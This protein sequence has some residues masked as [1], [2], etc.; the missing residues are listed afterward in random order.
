MNEGNEE[1]NTDQH[2]EV[3]EHTAGSGE[4][5]DAELLA[6]LQSLEG[7]NDFVLQQI[8]YILQALN[9]QSIALQA[10]Q[11]ILREEL[12][13]FQTGGP[14]RAMA[15]IFYRLFRDLLKVMNQL[16]ELAA[17]GSSGEHTDEEK[18]WLRSLEMLQGQME[19]ILI[20]WGCETMDIEVFV[21][22][23]DP[24]THEAVPA[25][26][27]MPAQDPEG[28]PIPEGTIVKVVQRGWTLQGAILQYP[29]VVVR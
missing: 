18:P 16:D 6:R 13:R 10:N 21:T 8:A 11:D 9:Q 3:D 14:Q 23:F 12:K 24:D 29:R 4:D 25:E 2:A 7:K 15:A 19:F 17:L 20:E 27:E 5:R 28:E 22:Q 26:E 1:K